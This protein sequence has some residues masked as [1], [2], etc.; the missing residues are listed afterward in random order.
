MFRLIAYI[1]KGLPIPSFCSY[2]ELA[3]Q[4]LL[5]F[6]LFVSLLVRISTFGGVT[7]YFACGLHQYLLNR[8]PAQF[9]KVWF[10]VDG[11]HWQSKKN[12]NKTLAPALVVTQDAQNHIT[13][14]D[15]KIHF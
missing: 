9:E 13:S 11:S 4:C 10:L 3:S 14:T 8:E 1:L 7:S 15:T 6:T 2:Q 12:Q 5:T